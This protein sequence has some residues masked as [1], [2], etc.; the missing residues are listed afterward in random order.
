MT[1]IRRLEIELKLNISELTKTQEDLKVVQEEHFKTEEFLKSHIKD[2]INALGK[3][4]GN[5]QT[6]PIDLGLS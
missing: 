1:E 6:L 3:Y 5:D 4:G 2:L